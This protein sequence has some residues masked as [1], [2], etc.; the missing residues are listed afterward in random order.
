MRQDSDRIVETLG[1][2]TFLTGFGLLI[3]FAL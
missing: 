2:I 3:Y 1:I